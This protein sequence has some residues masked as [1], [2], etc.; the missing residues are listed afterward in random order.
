MLVLGLG[1]VAG[2]AI[3][4]VGA[5]VGDAERIP[6][7]WVGAELRADGSTQVAEVIDYDFGLALDRH[8]IFRDVPGLTSD[9]A[10]SVRSASAPDAIAERSTVFIDGERGTRLRIGDAAVNVRGRHRYR[11]DYVH[12]SLQVA[13]NRIEWDAVGTAWA[14][15]VGRAEVHVVAPWELTGARCFVGS[16]GSTD[17]C[18]IERVAPGHLRVL[19]DDVG[20]DKG[21]TVS[22][23]RGADLA[24]APALPA[25]PVDAPPD[26][27]TGIGLPTAVG[28]VAGLGSALSTSQLV[29]RAGRERVGA[30]G[31]SDAAWSGDGPEPAGEVRL[32]A[33]QLAGLATI[34]FA[35]PEDLTPAQGGLV[36]AEAVRPEH[37]VA[38]LIQAAVEGAIE[39]E[40]HGRKQ[41]TLRRLAPGGPEIE[42]VLGAMFGSRKEVELGTYDKQFAKGWAKIDGRLER[43]A[44]Q[45]DL[46]DREADRAKTRLRALGVAATLLGALVAA[47]GGG[48]AN[49]YGAQWLPVVVVGALLGGGGLAAAVR[50]WELRVR[51]PRGSGTWLRVESFRRFL[52]QSESFHAEEAAKLGVLREYTAWAVA[53]GE[54]DRWERAVSASGAIPAEAG[55]GYV[56]MAPALSRSAVASSVAPSSSGGSGGGGGGSVG[57]GGG[58]GGGGSW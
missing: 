32:D 18:E 27:G 25:P 17:A 43:W 9:A 37:K 42:P 30:G 8:G 10:V 5:A 28:V 13:G 44:A 40:E 45:A 34:E 41:V 55:L 2:G 53:V 48:L 20:S 51:T 12:P 24:G 26:S 33:D 16:S 14:V 35:P 52:S 46:W 11:I 7:M 58:G 56:H 36:L 49:R 31:A 38:W 54:L 50:G 21:V 3:T 6:Q 47:V 4:A 57:G 1:A 39:L 19:V 15:P 23:D 29:R 22:A